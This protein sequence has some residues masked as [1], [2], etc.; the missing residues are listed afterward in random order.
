MSVQ[1]EQYG[2]EG[3]PIS[4]VECGT[5]ILLTG[6]ALGGVRDLVLRMLL[7]Q[8]AREGVL[9]LAADTNGPNVLDAFEALDGEVD[10]SR[11]GA[12]DCT[13]S[14]VADESRNVRSVGSPRDLT[15]VGIEFS[16]LYESLHG[17]GARHVRTGIYTLAPFVMYASLKPVY[18]FLHTLTGRIRTA[19]GLGVC[20][21]DPDAV[22]QQTLSSL[23]QAFDGRVDFRADDGNPAVR[24]R[25]LPGQ[26][27]GWTALDVA[28]V[29]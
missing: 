4:A 15:G 27:E 3:L 14:G 18:R 1:R 29:T 24:V 25:G 7:R 2:F 16:S 9:V 23:A 13:E 5:N 12:V 26:P 11:I 19:D 8:H 20:A 17:N 10:R 22:D 6:P 21:I 28:D